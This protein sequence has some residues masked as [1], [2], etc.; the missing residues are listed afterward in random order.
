MTE[1]FLVFSYH[2]EA[3]FGVGKLALHQIVGYSA[4]LVQVAITG[5]KPI[6][7]NSVQRWNYFILKSTVYFNYSSNYHSH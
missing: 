3:R 1:D 2:L 6:N 5:A 4:L 7:S